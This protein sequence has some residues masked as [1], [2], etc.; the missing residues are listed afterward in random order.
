AWDSVYPLLVWYLYEY[1]GDKSLVEKHYP[2]IKRYV[3]FLATRSKNGIVDYGLGDWVPAKTQTGAAITS[4][5]Y[6]FV[7][8]GILS[9]MAGLLGH[10]ED[11]KKYAAVAAGIKTAFNGRFYQPATGIYDNGSIAALSCALYQGLVEPE[12]KAKV[13]DNLVAEIKMQNYN[14]DVGILG[15][16]YVLNV[17]ADNG[18]IDVAYQMLQQRT[19]PSYGYWVDNGATTLW[20]DWGGKESL[21]HIMFGDVSAWF[22][23]YLA[24]INAASPGFRDIVIKPHVIG[25]L[26][27]AKASYESQ[28]GRIVSDWKLDKGVFQLT[29]IVPA[30]TNATVYVP[31]EDASKVNEGGRPIAKSSGVK[32]LRQEKE[33]SVFE[34]ASGTYR[35]SS[36]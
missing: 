35:F 22:Y 36:P 10:A 24:G 5:A 29:A 27:S 34:V 4:T 12:N 2:R 23:K 30:N 19:F 6:Y 20:E 32:L 3:D 9:K 31:A 7:D 8:A 18:R 33:Y 1:K 26:T 14:M 16:K 17:L 15:A 21:N 11:E 25:D 13:L 28:Q